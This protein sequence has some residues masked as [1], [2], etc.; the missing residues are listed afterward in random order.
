[1]AHPYDLTEFKQRFAELRERGFVRSRRN[2]PTGVGHTLEQELGMPENNLAVPDLGKV[3]LKARRVASGSMVTLFTFNRK[4]WQVKPL[5][6]VKTYGSPDKNGRI[7]LYYTMAPQPNGAGLFLHTESES[8]SVRHISG[9][10]IAVWNLEQLAAQFMKK[11]PAV[12]IANALT[13]L[14][15]GVE[16]FHY[17][18]AQLLYGTSPEILREQIL[19]GNVV[20]DLRLH[21]RATSARNHGTGFRAKENHLSQLFAHAEDV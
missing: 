11:I 6:A 4:V 14:R 2:G 12:V 20:V 15:D 16:W 19:A 3:E 5:Y 10:I 8:I 7:G 13:E 18:R 9:E 21:E 17:T 1:M